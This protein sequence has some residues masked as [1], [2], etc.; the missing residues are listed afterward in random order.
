MTT[1]DSGGEEPGTAATVEETKQDEPMEKNQSEE[2][3]ERPEV[4]VGEHCSAE[5]VSAELFFSPSV[6]KSPCRVQ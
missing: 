2:N 6:E 4:S 3:Q 1:K 5:V